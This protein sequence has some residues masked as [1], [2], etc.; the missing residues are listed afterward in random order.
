ML[1][2][3]NLSPIPIGRRVPDSGK[4]SSHEKF[5]D[6]GMYSIERPAEIQAVISNIIF[7]QCSYRCSK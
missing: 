3:V 7:M 4:Y 6:M 2:A 5:S 1:V